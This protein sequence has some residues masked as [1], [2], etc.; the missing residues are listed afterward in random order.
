MKV[1]ELLLE[2]RKTTADEFMKLMRDFLPLAM[3]HLKI[4]SLPDFKLVTRVP[5]SEQPTFG[6]FVPDENRIYLA[7][8]QRHP[9]DVL[10]T[11]AH[12]LT[13]FKQG[14]EHELGPDSGRTGSPQE[15]QAHEL[16]GIIM[17]NFNKAHPEYF[18]DR[19]INILESK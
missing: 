18:Q 14:V 11:L 19:A 7:V 15:N 17:R 3:Q 8:E 12:E 6:K 16:A 1:Y 13:H 10:R 4:D 5:D 2:E 9:L